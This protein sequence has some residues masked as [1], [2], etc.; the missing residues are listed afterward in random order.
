MK[1][2]PVLDLR[3]GQVVHAV[4]GQ[5]HQYQP[6]QSRLTN[7]TDPVDLLTAMQDQLGL[8]QFYVADLD[9]IQHQR[10]DWP[11]LQRLTRTG[12]TLMVDAG[13]RTV[14]DS[15][16]LHAQDLGAVQAVLGTES[17]EDLDS[18]VPDHFAN[19]IISIDL[20]NGVLQLACRSDHI[21]REPDALVEHLS[22]R[23]FRDFIILDVATVGTHQGIPTLSLITQ[24]Q[25]HCPEVRFITGGGIRSEACLKD[26]QRSRVHGLLIASAIHNGTL[27]RTEFEQLNL[28]TG[29]TTS[30][31]G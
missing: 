24:M 21:P 11:Q 1:I 26:A 27:G 31:D 28:H 17:F 23:G 4:A 2:Y 29:H 25:L 18:V 13:F 15:E 3:G 6:V 30:E 14:Q 19:G 10:P 7:S 8:N 16:R 5:R 12:A 20:R 9:G 22:R